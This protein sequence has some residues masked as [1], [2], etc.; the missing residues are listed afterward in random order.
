MKKI[1]A[2][3]GSLREGS[4]NTSLLKAM[5]MQAPEGVSIEIL[6]ISSLPLFNSDLETE[7]PAQATALKQAVESAYGIIFATPEYNRSIPGVLKNA[8][9]WASRPWGKNSFAGKVV[10]VVGASV[11][12]IGTAVAQQELKKIML[13]LD[14]RVIGQPEFYLGTAQ[15]KFDTQGMLTDE[16]TKQHI[17]KLFGVLVSWMK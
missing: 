6:D 8:I 4:F 13:Y 7:F 12:P 14:A 9:D 10:A 16:S 11:G 15:D 1:I 2:I 3:S 17:Q 5:Q